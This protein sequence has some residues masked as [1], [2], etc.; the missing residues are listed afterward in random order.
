VGIGAHQD[1]RFDLYINIYSGTL[2]VNWTRNTIYPIP[3]MEWKMLKQ[4]F[5]VFEKSLLH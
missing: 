4:G 1:F 2:F 5:K 3:P